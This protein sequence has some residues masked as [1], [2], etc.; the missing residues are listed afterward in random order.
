MK[1][2]DKVKKEAIKLAEEK[3]EDLPV[4]EERAEETKGAFDANGRLLIGTEQGL[5]VDK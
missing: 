2:E 1:T 3:L 5:F 4:T